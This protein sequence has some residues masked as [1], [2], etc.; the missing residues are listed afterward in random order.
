M[1]D[2]YWFESSVHVKDVTYRSDYCPL[3]GR[4][5]GYGNYDEEFGCGECADMNEL[6]A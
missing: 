1:T 2:E 4:K 6:G 5:V 3:C